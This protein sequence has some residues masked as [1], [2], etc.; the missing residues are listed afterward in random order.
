MPQE[1]NAGSVG[2]GDGR[3]PLAAGVSGLARGRWLLSRE[4]WQQTRE[5]LGLSSRELELVQHIFDG[6]KL[7]VIARDLNL[8]L[9]TVKTYSQRIHQKLH[10]SDQRELAL[11]VVSAHLQISDPAR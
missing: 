8:S 5:S 1:R 6:K 9:G 7:A 4:Q 10:V 3:P 11:A 2:D